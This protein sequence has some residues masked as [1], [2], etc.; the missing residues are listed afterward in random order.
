[1]ITLINKSGDLYTI[2]AMK[3]QEV[4]RELTLLLM[5]LSLFFHENYNLVYLNGKFE[6]YLGMAPAFCLIVFHFQ[7][8]VYHYAL[9]QE[10]HEALIFKNKELGITNSKNELILKKLLLI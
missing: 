4:T 7:F 2:K 10:E 1:M 3:S 6:F 8:N 9:N 5:S